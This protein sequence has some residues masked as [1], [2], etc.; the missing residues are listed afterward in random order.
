MSKDED[1]DGPD[2]EETPE[3]AKESPQKAA[4]AARRDAPATIDGRNGSALNNVWT[5]MKRE[6]GSYF[7]TP[8]AYILIC[9]TMIGLGLYVFL[10][11][12]GIWQTNRANLG[13]LMNFM[14]VVLCV[15]TIPLFTMRSLSEEKRMG[16]IE[17]L[18]TM[19]VKDSEVILGKYFAA[20]AMVCVQLL[21]LIAYPLIMFVAFHLGN[22]DWGPFWSGMLGLFLL[23]SAGVA[24]GLMYSSMTESQIL[25]FFATM[26]T[27]SVLY[28][29]GFMVTFFKGTFGDVLSFLSLETRFE[30]FSLGV[31]DTRAIVYF[32][33]IAV[34]CTLVS[35][36]NLESRKWN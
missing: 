11:N 7:N 36:R 22:F 17:I 25:S 30:P 31:I 34:F 21:L 18:I 24:V 20:L 2:S 32:V 19:P 3:S 23:S 28:V 8:L 5:I 6:L 15:L 16:T 14:P 26:M 29:I 13:L 33:S 35:F 27:L 12:G 1:K 10:F 4:P 9:V